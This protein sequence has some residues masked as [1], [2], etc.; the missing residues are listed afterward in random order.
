MGACRRSGLRPAKIFSMLLTLTML[1]LCVTSAT[2]SMPSPVHA[3]DGGGDNSGSGGGDDDGSDDSG[4]GGGDEDGG[5]AN[6]GPGGGDEEDD[7]SSGS[8]DDGESAEKHGHGRH[9]RKRH[10]RET[11]MEL[12]FGARQDPDP[13]AETD[14]LI[15]SPTPVERARIEAAGF[16]VRDAQQLLGLDLGVLRVAPPFGMSVEQAREMLRRLLPGRTVDHD[17]AYELQ[18]AGCGSAECW[19]R[20]LVEWSPRIDGCSRLLQIGIID[21]GVARDHPALRDAR[22][23]VFA[24]LDGRPPAPVEHGTRIAALFAGSRPPG[25]LPGARLFVSNVFFATAKGPRTGPLEIARGLDWLLRKGVPVINLSLA[26][27]D[28]AVLRLAIERARQR[29]ATLVAAAGNYGP[30]APPAYPAAYP[31]VVAVTAVDARLRPYRYANRGPYIA[32]A[33]PG[34]ALPVAS[35]RGSNRLAS[36]TSYATVFVTAAS[37]L[38]KLAGASPPG[39]ESALARSALDL[40][41]P[42]RDPVFGWGLVRLPRGCHG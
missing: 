19:P 17:D 33:A 38:A 29:G 11:L 40:G 12:L 30:T 9:G 42:G 31:G 24:A 1:A 6:S 37:A 7:D 39:L 36:G 34:V 21:T 28:N 41:P 5:S 22:I 32:F 23:D 25:L 35:T 2:L 16:R 8:G 20:S 26:G 4:S 3:D 13:R 10:R 27:P 18:D 15:A 14:L